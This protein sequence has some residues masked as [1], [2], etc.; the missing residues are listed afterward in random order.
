MKQIITIIFLVFTAIGF[1]AFGQTT[2]NITTSGNWI[3]PVGV[4]SVTVECTGGGARGGNNTMNTQSSGGGGGAFAS[5]TITVIPG[6]TYSVVIGNGGNQTTANG[7]DTYFINNTTV[8]AKGGQAPANHA[9]TGANGGTAAASV[10]T[11]KFNGGNGGNV[12]GGNSGAGG[13]GAGTSGAGGNGVGTTAGAGAALNG[14]NGGVGRTNNNTNGAP[15]LT[16]GG[17]GSGGKGNNNTGGPGAP[18]LVRLTFTCPTITPDAGIDQVLASCATTTSVTGSAIP[19]GATGTWTVVSGTATITTPNNATTNITNIPLGTTVVLRWSISNGACGT[20]ADDI[21]ITTSFGPGCL[22]YCAPG[23]LNCGLNDRIH[24][25]QLGTLDNSS[26][27]TCTA[28]TGYSD[29]STTVAAPTLIVGDTYNLSITVGTGTGTHSAGIWIDFNQNG[30][31]LD[32]GEFFSIGQGTILPNTTVTIPVTVP[33]NAQLGNTRIRIAYV[34]GNSLLSSWTCFTNATFGETEDYTV[35]IQCGFTP[36]AITDRFP[37]NGLPL[38]CGSAVSLT[39]KD[40]TC[41]TGYKVYLG[42]SNPPLTLVADQITN[43]YY[44]GNLASNTTYYWNVVP[45]NAN[46]DGASNVWSFTTDVAINTA[47]SQDEDDCGESGITLTA[48]G[49]AFPDY[50]WYNVPFGGV[51]IHNGDTYSPV[52]LTDPTTFY[53][54]N[55]FEGPAATI[56]ASNVATLTCSGAGANPRGWGVFFDIQAKSANVVITQLDLMFRDNGFNPAGGITNRPVR[57]YYR[58]ESYTAN[59]NNA[60]G[61]TLSEDIN[62]PVINAPGAPTQVDITDVFIPAG[63]VYGFYIVYDQVIASGANIYANP[64]L[65]L[66]TGST[67]CGS[68]FGDAFSDFTFR[69]TVHYTT[70]CTSPTVPVLAT[71]YVSNNEVTLAL[72]TVI[73]AEEQCSEGGW[74]YYADPAVPNDWLF[75]INKNGNNFTATV[76]IIETPTVYSNINTTDPHGSFLISRYWNVNVQTG[77]VVDPVGVRFFFD[78]A[79]IRSAFNLRNFE[80]TTNYPAT[81]NVDWRWFKTVGVPFDPN[82]GIDGN[83]FNFANITPNNVNNLALAGATYTGFINNVAYVEFNGL[84]S[85]SG[86]TG[87]YGFSIYENVALSVELLDFQAKPEQNHNLVTW[88]TASE[89]NNDY[90]ILESSS[91]GVN[92]KSITTIAGNGNSSQNINY[93][94]NDFEYFSPKTFYRLIQVDYDGEQH[95]S[96]VI[97]VNRQNDFNDMDIVLYPNPSTGEVNLKTYV[98]NSGEVNIRVL[99][100]LGELIYNEKVNLKVGY[101]NNTFDFSNLANGI[102]AIEF[103]NQFSRKVVQFVKQ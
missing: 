30:S 90:F 88:T 44:T 67:V 1:E 83:I 91:D 47:I 14:G 8:M 19:T 52:G 71:P 26:V 17:A 36:T 21:A 9:T 42:T 80:R 7:G 59:V 49:G 73:A 65:E 103:Q 10:G 2:Q 87:G 32:P 55:V 28:T 64:D 35:N 69:G 81:N 43:S 5:S 92:F 51:P 25:V 78:T 76:D 68:E 39:W 11:T 93:Q 50:Y 98:E 102:Y 84:T 63:S 33:T 4:T 45:Y 96:Q 20:V 29:Y 38:P 72:N 82:V 22:S 40:H 37:A 13:G 6:N 85:F 101:N 97:T 27:G 46:G 61:W 54:A 23:N 31:F 16:Y 79:E 77:S 74:T 95:K 89:T 58:P 3:A 57:V 66:I 53:V 56:N 48:S 15:G 75:A 18:G 41:A 62:V 34:Y 99:N 12:V 24:R 94:F 70:N 86:G 60:T 100:L